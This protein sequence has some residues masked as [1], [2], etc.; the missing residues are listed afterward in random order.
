MDGRNIFLAKPV[1]PA[2]GKYLAILFF[3]LEIIQVLGK[4][5]R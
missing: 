5:F 2:I 4:I 3:E 1:L